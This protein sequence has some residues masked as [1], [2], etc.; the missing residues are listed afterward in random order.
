M[1]KWRVVAFGILRKKMD[2]VD[3][4]GPNPPVAV[5]LDRITCPSHLFTLATI[6]SSPP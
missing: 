2:M 6:G 1:L 5:S 4:D 3:V